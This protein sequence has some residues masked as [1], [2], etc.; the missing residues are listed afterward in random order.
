MISNPFQCFSH[1]THRR[2]TTFTMLL[3][4]V[5]FVALTAWPAMSQLASARS[6]VFMSGTLQPVDEVQHQLGVRL[7]HSATAGVTLRRS[8]TFVLRRGPTAALHCNSF[9][10]TIHAVV[11]EVLDAV[12]RIA[13]SV[14][15]GVLVFFPSYNAL[16]A[17]RNA[18]RSAPNFANLVRVKKPLWETKCKD[19]FERDFRA[20]TQANDAAR[21][22][23]RRA[24]RSTGAIFF[25]V[26]RGKLSEGIDFPDHQC[27]AV[28]LVG[29]PYAFGGDIRVRTM[30]QFYDRRSQLKQGD[31]QTGTQWYRADAFAAVN[32]AIG[33]S[34]RHDKDW[35]AVV[36]LD[37]RY[38]SNVNQLPAWTRNNIKFYDNFGSFVEDLQEYV[39]QQ[40][41]ADNQ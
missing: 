7:H 36:L 28:A 19:Q 35:A 1:R 26:C 17:F 13:A 38:H 29:V 10:L 12:V 14:P 32:Q 20:Y 27:R 33:R 40:T 3:G 5:H 24:D 16:S 11:T 41:A 6:L 21:L 25:G 39:D 23:P 18:S 9:S 22:R 30:M 37:Q 4:V 8:K 15:H 2:T 31:S 34:V